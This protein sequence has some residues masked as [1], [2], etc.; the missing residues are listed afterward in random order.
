M[1][2]DSAPAER[3]GAPAAALRL[4]GITKRFG[5][6][7]A[8][9]DVSLSVEPGEIHALLG[10]NGAGK[11]TLMN[12][13]FG[14]LQADA[15][16]IEVHGR[17]ARIRSPRD[18]HEFKVGM[19]HQHFK[20]VPDM[21]VAEN[22]VLSLGRS[23]LRR[24]RL[25]EV[26]ARV[27]ELADRFG[28]RIDPDRVIEDLTVGEHQKVEILK[29]LY[30][31]VDL[32]ILDEPTAT[33]TPQEWQQLAGVLRALAG[34]G[35]S[36]VFI[37]HKLGE[38][39]EVADR[40]TVLRDGRVVGTRQLGDTS[41]EELARLMVG[42]EVALRIVREDVA[43]G[44][45]VLEARDL[46]VRRDGREALAGVDIRLREGEVLGVAGVDGNGQSELVDALIG[47]CELASGQIYV[48]GADI[49]SH[50]RRIVKDPRIGVIPEDR[51]RDALALELSVADN[52]MMKDFDVAPFARRGLRD[53]AAARRRCR[54]LVTA[55]D[56][57]A[58]SL[59]T[60]LRQLSGGNQQ[61]VVV[62]RE[63]GRNPR[64]L[65]AAQ[66]TRGLDVGAMEFIYERLAE[67]KRSGGAALLISTELEEVLSLSDRIAVMVG[68][69][70]VRTL[71]TEDATLEVIGM[72][73]AGAGAPD[74]KVAA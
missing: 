36:I 56:I 1:E 9:D 38:V 70:F 29:L 43:P 65:I 4:H 73:M 31:E 24:L 72:L 67:F 53:R 44:R 25:R 51:H 10:E 64:L 3:M 14:L 46:R 20:L 12:V 2:S 50:G 7:V 5:D 69:R 66:P 18:A 60:P 61:K 19:V 16:T 49:A 59:D 45:L 6:V 63:L 42:R 8:N 52:L 23:G 37:T 54:E 30:R 71:R 74:G 28:L 47:A 62:A 58:A 41:K 40:C 27:A 57:R 35:R 22:I 33:L 34:E 48:Q 15:G 32:L 39:F 21:T 13:A 68:G 17:E 26:S 11:S 55:F